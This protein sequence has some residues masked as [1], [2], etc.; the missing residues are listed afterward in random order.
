MHCHHRCMPIYER[1]PIP[2]RIRRLLATAGG[3]LTTRH[4]AE[5]AG[6]TPPQAARALRRLEDQ[7]AAVRQ[8]ADGGCYAWTASATGITG[9]L[10][11]APST[12]HAEDTRS[13][14]TKHD[15]TSTRPAWTTR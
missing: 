7:H 8:L 9:A 14:P 13:L 1:P 12:T 10:T 2:E 15:R 5:Q 4:I 3:P 6:T 11:A